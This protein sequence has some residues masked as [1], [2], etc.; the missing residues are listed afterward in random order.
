[1]QA[2]FVLRGWALCITPGVERPGLGKPGLRCSASDHRAGSPSWT[3]TTPSILSTRE[4]C[5]AV[6]PTAARRMKPAMS[7]R[8]SRDHFMRGAM[9][10]AVVAVALPQDG[11]HL[12]EPLP[13]VAGAAPRADARRSAKRYSVR[14]EHLCAPSKGSRACP[15]TPGSRPA[16]S[17]PACGWNGMFGVM[18]GSTWSPE[19]IRR[20]GRL[21]EAQVARRV[22]RRPDRGEVPPRHL[23]PRTVLEQHVGHAPGPPAAGPAWRRSAAA[24]SS[25]GG[26]PMLAAGPPPP[27]RRAGRRAHVVAVVD[28]LRRRPGC[29]EIQ[30][31]DASRIRPA[32]PKWSGWM[33]VTIT[34]WTSAIVA[35]GHL[36]CPL[37]E[38]PER[39]VRVPARRPVRCTGPRS[40]SESVHQ[41]VPQR[42]VRQRHRDAP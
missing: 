8:R 33:W 17:A 2:R 25:L 11:D 40:V 31:P 10:H 28:Q 32:S 34:P 3:R 42:V 39:V 24:P 19:S 9:S 7:S 38:G 37:C 14:R 41:H 35:A 27:V 26:A 4:I 15:A 21:V 29:S 20:T 12:G 23:G 1:M 5:G 6:S 13:V 36:R 18:R 16:G 30:A 22:A